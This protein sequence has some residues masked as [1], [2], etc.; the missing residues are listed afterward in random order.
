VYT[1]GYTDVPEDVSQAAIL[2]ASV[3]YTRGRQGADGIASE[4]HGD[5]YS[6]TYAVDLITPEI[7]TLL[8]PYREFRL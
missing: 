1:A 8:A 4:S 5:A 6:V 7:G 3:L 2:L